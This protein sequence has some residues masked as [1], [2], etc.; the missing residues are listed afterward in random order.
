MW[1]VEQWGIDAF[2]ALQSEFCGVDLHMI[3]RRVCHE[4]LSHER[5]RSGA[6][7]KL[8]KHT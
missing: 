7:R 1:A 5:Q 4:K 8:R 3:R 2:A 6:A